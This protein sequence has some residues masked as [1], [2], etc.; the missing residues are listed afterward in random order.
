[1]KGGHAVVANGV[2]EVEMQRDTTTGAYTGYVIK[3]ADPGNTYQLFTLSVP[4]IVGVV[5]EEQSK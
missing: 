4:D 5:A 2:K 1:M 3:W